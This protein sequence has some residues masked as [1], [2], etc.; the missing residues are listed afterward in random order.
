MIGCNGKVYG[1]GIGVERRRGE[2][3]D[4]GVVIEYSIRGNISVVH[5]HVSKVKTNQ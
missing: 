1:Y 4:G 3:N 5:C 2:Y